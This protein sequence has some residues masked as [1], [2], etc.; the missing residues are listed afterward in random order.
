[1]HCGKS[2]L[3]LGQSVYSLK[4]KASKLINLPCLQVE[5]AT[6]CK[7][8]QLIM[9]YILNKVLHDMH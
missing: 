7:P 9:L 8:P 5:K 6:K 1:M 3:Y 4:A 2:R